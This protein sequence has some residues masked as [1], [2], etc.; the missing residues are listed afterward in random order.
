MGLFPTHSEKE[1][2]RIRSTVD[3]VM[4]LEESYSKLTDQELTG[5]T[6]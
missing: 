6:Q 2:K 3:K 4:S 5:K 1:L